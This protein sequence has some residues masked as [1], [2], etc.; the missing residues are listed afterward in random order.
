MVFCYVTAI[1]I[2]QSFN[3]K[4]KDWYVGRIKQRKILRAA[5]NE[6]HFW[7]HCASLG[8]FEQARTII[9]K[10]RSSHPEIFISL[11]FF[12]PSGYEIRKN[13]AQVD[14]V[15]YLPGD[16]PKRMGLFL[17][18]LKP[19]VCIFINNEFWANTLNLLCKKNIPYLFVSSNFKPK[20]FGFLLKKGLFFKNAKK[21]FLSQS[22]FIDKIALK[23]YTNFQYNGDTRVDR[24]L[25]IHKQSLTLPIIE[26]FKGESE[27]IIF[28]SAYKEEMNQALHIANHPQFQDFKFII[29]PHEI[30]TKQIDL[31]EH[32]FSKL[33]TVRYSELSQE[34]IDTNNANVLILDT[35]GHLSA[36]YKYASVCNYWWRFWKRNSQYSGTF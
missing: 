27:L 19:D 32:M 9:E 11:S 22:Q 36:A 17:E 8:E 1:R 24:V 13:F 18:K 31:A 6:K 30:N 10:L 12:S 25:H 35:V 5:N 26:K 20:H 4:A 16:L 28:G 23:G 33:A 3:S 7:F 2:V 29:A 14:Q 34:S 15:L 21:I